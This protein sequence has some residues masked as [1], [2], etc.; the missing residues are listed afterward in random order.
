MQG[1]ESEI[2]IEI[3]IELTRHSVY[4]EQHKGA[5]TV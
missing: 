5:L 3:G 2:E 1:F 4:S